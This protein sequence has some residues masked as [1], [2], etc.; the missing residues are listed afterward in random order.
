M[1]EWLA[2]TDTRLAEHSRLRL[3]IAFDLEPI[4]P[5]VVAVPDYPTVPLSLTICL[6]R[7]V[8]TCLY[9]TKSSCGCESPTCAAM[10]GF[11]G[12]VSFFDCIDCLKEA[13][14]PRKD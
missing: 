9:R 3:E 2:G 1:R 10:R 8:D 13:S 5:L 11:D 4:P 12:K 7:Q 6:Q 14:Q